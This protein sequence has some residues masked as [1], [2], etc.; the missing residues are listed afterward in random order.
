M[1]PTHLDKQHVVDQLPAI[2]NKKERRKRTDLDEQHVVDQL[3]AIRGQPRDEGCDGGVRAAA[4]AHREIVGHR[5]WS[6]RAR[7]VCGGEEGSW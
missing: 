3:P 2:E 1:Q 7:G 5:L 4:R 6:A